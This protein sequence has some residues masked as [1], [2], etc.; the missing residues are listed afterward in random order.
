M[1]EAVDHHWLL[2]VTEQQPGCK[3]KFCRVDVDAAEQERL[4]MRVKIR[5]PSVKETPSEQ[6]AG[7]WPQKRGLG[8]RGWRER[9]GETGA[10][11]FSQQKYW[12]EVICGR[13][14]YESQTVSP[15]D[16]FLF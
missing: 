3:M 6:Q 4:V 13:W 1:R 16:T 8:V 10:P 2:P 14:A 15:T 11:S 12:H 5:V 9:W 7:G